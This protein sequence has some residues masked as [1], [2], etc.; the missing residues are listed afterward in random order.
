[1]NTKEERSFL[2]ACKACNCVKVKEYLDKGVDVNVTDEWGGFRGFALKYVAIVA[3]HDNRENLQLLDVLLACSSI[4]VNNKDD[5]GRTALMWASFAGSQHVAQRLLDVPG[6]DINHQDIFGK[7]ALIIS[8][9]HGW[10]NI[11]KKMLAHPLINFNHR[12]H[13]GRT[14][15]MWACVNGKMEVVD[16][17]LEIPEVD[18]NSRDNSGNTAL[19]LLFEKGKEPYALLNLLK[20][21]V[22]R[23]DIDL[24]YNIKNTLGKDIFTISIQRNYVGVIQTL[25][26]IP[27][28]KPDVK[29]LKQ[30]NVYEEAVRQCR[31]FVSNKMTFPGIWYAEAVSDAYIYAFAFSHGM[32]NIAKVIIPDQDTAVESCRLLV[33]ERMSN[34]EYLHPQ[35]NMTELVYALEKGLDNVALVLAS[36]VKVSDILLMC[37]IFHVEEEKVRLEAKAQEMI[38]DA[39]PRKR[40]KLE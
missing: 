36:G 22:E 26:E 14:A 8:C 9:G 25:L 13:Y 12:D 32:K 23:D 16:L 10:T 17:F 29:I 19:M 18:F 2:N 5:K 38:E 15:F 6:I 21:V 33:A 1:M 35:H 27:T 4:N 34:D 11:V 3:R 37:K 7:T 24:D 30:M 39:T 31:Q 40:S 28:L 20:C